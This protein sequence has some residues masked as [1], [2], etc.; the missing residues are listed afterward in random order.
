MAETWTASTT[1][2]PRDLKGEVEHLRIEGHKQAF[3][4]LDEP[5][6]ELLSD[7]KDEG[8]Y[9]HAWRQRCRD[10]AS[11]PDYEEGDKIRLAAPVTV[12]DGSTCQIVTATHYRRGRQNAA[13]TASRKPAGSCACR[14]PRL[15]ARSCSA[16]RRARP[17]RCWRSIS[18]GEIRCCA[19]RLIDLPG[20]GRSCGLS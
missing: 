2:W 13:A 4:N 11:I 15:P 20:D 12:T 10:W 9:A 16:P 7:L 14:K 5:L 8:S 3:A 18:Q 17:A 1:V 19:G 6:I